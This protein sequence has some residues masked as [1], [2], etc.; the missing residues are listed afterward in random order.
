MAVIPLYVVSLVMGI[1]T[2]R[3]EKQ[4][5]LMDTLN[6]LFYEMSAKQKNDCVIVIFVAEVRQYKIIELTERK[7]RDFKNT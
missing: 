5:Y 2:V 4:T 1:P 6:S 3:R 7:C